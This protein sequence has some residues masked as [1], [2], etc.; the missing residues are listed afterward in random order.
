MYSN[1]TTRVYEFNDVAVEDYDIYGKNPETNTEQYTAYIKFKNFNLDTPEHYKIFRAG[2][3]QFSKAYK[4]DFK[5]FKHNMYIDNNFTYLPYL[6]DMQLDQFSTSP[7]RWSSDGANVLWD[8]FYWS[9]ENN[10]AYYF[11][12]NAKGRTIQNELKFKTYGKK[13]KILG[14]SF[15]VKL[16]YPQRNKFNTGFKRGN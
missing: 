13:I 9:G 7:D 6:E 3:I 16:K 11:R 10:N 5:E 2:W 4:E 14:T 1:K 12:I 8:N 15:E